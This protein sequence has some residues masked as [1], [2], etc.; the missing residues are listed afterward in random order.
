ML[1]PDARRL[2]IAELGYADAALASWE[3]FQRARDTGTIAAHQ[4]FMVGLPSPLSVVTMY[5][6]PAS[7]PAVLEAWTA[8]MEKEVSRILDNI[9]SDSLAIQWE[10][11]IEFGI[12][13]GVWTYLDSGESGIAARSEIAQHVLH[14]GG[15]IPEPVELGYHF[16]LRGCWPP[17]LYRAFRRQPSRLG[18][19]HRVRGPWPLGGVDSP[20]GTTHSRRRRILST[21]SGP[22]RS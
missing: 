19:R 13:E 12:L 15:L 1:R 22:Q 11:V 4:R 10:V 9:P 8:V 3:L 21:A 7:R 2:D 20:A 6:A 17:A 18:G 5:I 16:L 14:L